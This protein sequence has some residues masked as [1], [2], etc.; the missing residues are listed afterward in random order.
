MAVPGGA[1][2]IFKVH[3]DL[4]TMPITE[5]IKPAVQFVREGIVV[6]SFSAFALELLEVIFK[7]Q[8]ESFRVFRSL[9]DPKNLLKKGELYKNPDLADTLG[10]LA[11]KGVYEFY[12]GEIA[13]HC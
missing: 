10:Y 13:K 4:G 11:K 3:V 5:L 1:K 12:N 7:A 2:G 6:N 8:P 9:S